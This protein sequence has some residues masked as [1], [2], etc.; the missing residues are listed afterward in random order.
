MRKSQEKKKA[1]W[2]A[3]GFPTLFALSSSFRKKKRKSKGRPASINPLLSVPGPS[4]A[5]IDL[6]TVN[7]ENG[8]VAMETDRDFHLFSLIF[9]FS[10]SLT[11]SFPFFLLFYIH[12]FIFIFF[13]F[14]AIKVRRGF[15]F[16]RLIFDNRICIDLKEWVTPFQYPPS[17]FVLFFF[18]CFFLL[19]LFS[20]TR[21]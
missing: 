4:I 1:V 3:C 9:L 6:S 12:F 8:S 19:L 14:W 5:P 10:L 17:S 21:P 16:L 7:W 15:W 13:S 20:R 2:K 18:P 11:L